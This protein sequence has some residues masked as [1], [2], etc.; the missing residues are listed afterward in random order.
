[1]SNPEPALTIGA[2]AAYHYRRT[3]RAEGHGSART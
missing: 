2:V 3:F 1:M